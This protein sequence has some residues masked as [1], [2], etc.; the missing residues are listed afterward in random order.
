[1][2][3]ENSDHAFKINGVLTKTLKQFSGV[4]ESSTNFSKITT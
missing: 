2:A 3:I 1:M 4:K